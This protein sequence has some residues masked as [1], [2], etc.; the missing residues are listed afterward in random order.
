MTALDRR[1]V[2]EHVAIVMIHATLLAGRQPDVERI[3]RG[4]FNVLHYGTPDDLGEL[5][6]L[7]VDL[8]RAVRQEV[9]A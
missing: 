5:C 3:T 2:A 1:T 4:A 9:V 7:M 6:D 8:H